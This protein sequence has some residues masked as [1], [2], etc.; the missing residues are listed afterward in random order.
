M[1]KFQQNEPALIQLAVPEKVYII[2]FLSQ[3]PDFGKYVFDE[4]VKKVCQN[5]LLLKVKGGLIQIGQGLD[6]DIKT[7]KK[8]FSCNEKIVVLVLL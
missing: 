2:D 8:K 3:E 5:P 7:L 4:F 6:N 1:L